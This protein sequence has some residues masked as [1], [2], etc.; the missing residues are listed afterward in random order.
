MN[1]PPYSVYLI[2][3][4]LP[5]NQSKQYVGLTIR[6]LQARLQAHRG[7]AA[8]K[9]KKVAKGSLGEAMRIEFQRNPRSK[10]FDIALLSTHRS[11]NAVRRAE[12]RAIEKWGTVAPYGYNLMR[13]GSSV[14]GPS[15]SKSVTVEAG[16]KRTTF[17]SL[18]A[19]C[20]V[21]CPDD[22]SDETF[23]FRV[24]RRRESGW[25]LEQ[26]IGLVPGPDR[27]TTERSRYA[28]S[29][30]VSQATLRSRDHR[31]KTRLAPFVIE[32]PHPNEVRRKVSAAEFSRITGISKST[33][34]YRAK[35]LGEVALNAWSRGR[36]LK[37][38]LTS[39]ARSTTITVIVPSRS[40][41]V[42]GTIRALARRFERGKKGGGRFLADT[43]RARL[44]KLP[45]P[46]RV[47]NDDV[48]AALGL[49]ETL[50]SQ[51]MSSVQ[52]HVRRT[53][54]DDWTVRQGTR[55][56]K[57]GNQA[58]FCRAVIAA[59][60]TK[61]SLSE[62]QKSHTFLTCDRSK[63][64]AR[65]QKWVSNQAKVGRSPTDIARS[66]DMLSRLFKR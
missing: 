37:A 27:R 42:E 50:P 35:K 38:M 30:G 13:G 24:V 40:D 5:R 20:R 44:A 22:L 31:R 43:I 23:Y 54:C 47:R 4:K 2:T 7:T 51:R 15:N 14:G 18:A 21:M 59:L 9:G 17:E 57:F 66:L 11:L 52:A 63:R 45:F 28:R 55:L 41:A 34:L 62:V 61:R 19:L 10:A 53:Y 56:I 64:H 33:V 65:L 36:L 1:R 8:R 6:T 12:I 58:D 39:S 16:D 25:S 3:H 46:K 49:T 60:P 48:L 26:A 29:S 32:L